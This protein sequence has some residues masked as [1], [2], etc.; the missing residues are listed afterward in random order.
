[1]KSFF[2]ILFLFCQGAVAGLKKLHEKESIEMQVLYTQKSV[3]DL[4]IQQLR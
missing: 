1:M 3:Q 4:S 2:L